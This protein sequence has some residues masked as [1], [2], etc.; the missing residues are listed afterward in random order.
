MSPEDLKAFYITGIRSV[1]DYA[2][3]VFHSSL[4]KYLI[5]EIEEI[6]KS[7]ISIILPKQEYDVVLKKL[8]WRI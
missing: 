1:L 4:P 3:P 6:Q 7:V 8:Q 5:E 2:V